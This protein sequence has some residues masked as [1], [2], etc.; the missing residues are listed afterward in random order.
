VDFQRKGQSVLKAT[1]W[2]GYV[3]ILTGI[4]MEKGYSVS[5]NYRRTDDGTF[6]NNLKTALS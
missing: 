4:R 5:V 6:S 3:G 2:I 1:T